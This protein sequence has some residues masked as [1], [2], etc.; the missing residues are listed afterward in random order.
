MSSSAGVEISNAA[1]GT[2]GRGGLERGPAPAE[3]TRETPLAV[4]TRPLCPRLMHA[5][6]L[7]PLARRLQLMSRWQTQLMWP[8]D[9]AGKLKVI[10]GVQACLAQGIIFTG[11]IES[12]F[13]AKT[14]VRVEG[15]TRA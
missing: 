11:S 5:L 13:M 4:S 9:I 15:F 7:H 6:H 10:P 12:A 3:P 8:P 2:T 14:M 1:V